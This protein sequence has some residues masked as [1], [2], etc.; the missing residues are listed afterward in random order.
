M[1]TVTMALPATNI[2]WCVCLNKGQ[3]AIA[4]MQWKGRD[5]GKVNSR[6]PPLRDLLPAANRVAAAI[7]GDISNVST[8]PPAPVRS[9]RNWTPPNLRKRATAGAG[10]ICAVI[11]A[12]TTAMYKHASLDGPAQ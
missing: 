3:P 5:G 9:S 1:H 7:S 12:R 10:A 4:L 2:S 8:N 6:M 11:S